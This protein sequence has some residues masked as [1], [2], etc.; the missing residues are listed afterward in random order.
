MNAALRLLQPIFMLI[1]FAFLV[2]PILVSASV[3]FTN[4]TFMG[5]PPSGFSFRWYR[6]LVDDPVWRAA[7]LDTVVIGAL[8]TVFA[9]TVGT[10]SAYGIS[11]IHSPFL[12][13]AIL[14][15]FLAPLAVPYVSFGMAIYPIFAS[16]HLIGTRLGVALAQAIISLPFVVITV[17]STQRRRDRILENAART[18]GARP[19][20]AFRY[21]VLPMLAPGI[22]AGAILAFMTSFDD[23]IMPIFLGGGDVSTVPKTMLDSLSMSSDPSVMA[24]STVISMIGLIAYLTL[25]AMRRHRGT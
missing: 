2:A 7:L 21:I 13:N 22:V 6:G 15:I 14:V 8:C 23:V 17:I 19:L 10:L 25:T 20:A 16:Y 18:L 12:R 3:S 9:T 4:D 11:R 24:A 1:V 5:F